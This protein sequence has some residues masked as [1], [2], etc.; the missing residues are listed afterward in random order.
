MKEVSEAKPRIGK[1]GYLFLQFKKEGDKTVLVDSFS[2]IPLQVLPPFYLD[3]NTTAYSYILNPTGGVVGGDNLDI[4]IW[5]EPGAHAFLTTPSAT[6]VYRT[7]GPLAQQRLIFSLKRDSVLEYLPRVT[8]PFAGSS[9]YQNAL[10]FM[11]EGAKAIFLDIFSAGRKARGEHLAFDEYRSIFEAFQVER[12]SDQPPNHTPGLSHSLMELCNIKGSEKWARLLMSDRLLLK[13]RNCNYSGLGFFGSFSTIASMY[14]IFSDPSIQ[15]NLNLLFQSILEE[16]KNNHNI[17]GG[18]SLLPRRGLFVR[19][20]G[21]ETHQ[22]EQLIS[23]LW[24]VA[25]KEI[26]SIHE[27]SLARL[28]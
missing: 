27:P 2:R 4:E 13:P 21:H 3:K 14:L 19:I 16:Q 17:I 26:L 9:F 20:L 7:I 18:V 24:S 22:L 25:R 5:L 28:F 11:E 12:Q 8:I 10:L 6:K 1:D 15:S 23:V